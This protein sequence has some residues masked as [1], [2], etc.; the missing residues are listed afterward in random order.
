MNDEDFTQISLGR[1]RVGIAGLKAAIDELKSWQERPEAEIAQA[2]L[3]RLKPKNYI[4]AAAED[5]YR[6][7]CLREFK[8]ALGEEVEEEE[9]GLNLKILGAGCPACDQLA[10]TVMA[11]VTELGLPAE[12]EYVSNPKEI[13]ALGV[14]GVP[15]LLI[16]NVVKIAGR[17]PTKQ[18]LRNW[19]LEFMPIEKNSP[20]MP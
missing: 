8:K 11:V 1:L 10:Q 5:E 9:S 7:A 13:L 14:L 6:R 18:M 12:V 20:L 16:N 3:E 17:L 2:L 19:L 4:P 15:A